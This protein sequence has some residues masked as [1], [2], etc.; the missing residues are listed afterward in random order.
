VWKA[1]C[2]GIT[3]GQARA[4]RWAT[5]QHIYST[6]HFLF[7]RIRAGHQ[8]L[9][10]DSDSLF[11]VGYA[12]VDIDIDVKPGAALTSRFKCRAGSLAETSLSFK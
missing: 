6:G 3:V 4:S 10:V 9:L 2:L 1:R 7:S 11:E 5:P 12:V 8:A